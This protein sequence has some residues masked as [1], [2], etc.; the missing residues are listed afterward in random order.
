LATDGQLFYVTGGLAISNVKGDFLFT[1][2]FGA[3]QSA[4][5]NNTEVGYAVGAGVEW[6]VTDPLRLRAEYLHVNFD[7]I[8][9]NQ[10]SSNIA[11]QVFNQSTALTADIVRLGANYR[12]ESPR[13]WASGGVAAKPLVAP[14]WPLPVV[15][16]SNWE[17]DG[18]SRSWFSTG[19]VGA[20]QPLLNIPPGTLASRLTFRDLNAYSGE[21]FARVDESSG[22]FA[23]ALLGAGGIATG[24]L[25]DEDFP[26]FNAYSNTISTSSGD[27]GYASADLGYSFIQTPFAKVGGFIGY[28]SL[29]QHINAFGCTQLAGDSGVCAPGVIAPRFMGITEDDHIR[30]FRIGLASQ[31]RL[32]E[33]WKFSAEAAYMPWVEFR[34][35][36]DHNARELLLPEQSSEGDG[37]MLE[38]AVGYDVTP[39]WNVGV[40]GR[41]WAWNLRSGVERFNFLG[42]PAPTF[43]E[44]AGFSTE[45]YG[46][47]LQTSYR[48]GDTWPLADLDPSIQVKAPAVSVTP[49]NWAGFY[50]GGH[51]GGGWSDDQWSD[52]F[53][54]GPSGLGA[55]NVAGFGDTVHSTGPLGGAQVGANWQRGQWV[56]GVQGDV[57]ATD[58]RGESTCFSGIGGINCQRRQFD[59]HCSRA[60]GFCLGPLAGL[61]KGGRCM[62]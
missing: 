52:P 22:L 31:Y 24:K 38:V 45:R 29:T 35:Q 62:G 4:T 50:I 44:P 32:S 56:F 23:K 14:T 59:Q 33:R 19:G 27:L 9:A 18:G 51:L 60:G 25:N 43:I 46:L 7:R 8:V 57:S 49:M 41:Y 11:S 3:R 48:L 21:I 6:A 20:P 10:S 12:F 55:V 40:G 36:D 61:C 53:A 42:A 28:N 37:V 1:D 26:G 34:G 39:T 13:P 5:I 17:F 58:L 16:R 30:S 47:F 54:S 15:T 2:S